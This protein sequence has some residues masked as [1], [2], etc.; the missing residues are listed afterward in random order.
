MLNCTMI[1]VL[2]MLHNIMHVCIVG[3]NLSFFVAIWVSYLVF[4]AEVCRG[5]HKWLL[6]NAILLFT[7]TILQAT[8]YVLAAAA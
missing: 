4:H 1:C 2:G 8:A 5:I 3:L 6:S 7:T